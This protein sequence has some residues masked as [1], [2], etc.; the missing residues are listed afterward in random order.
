[1]KLELRHQI[2][3]WNLHLR[4]VTKYLQIVPVIGCA[5]CR[6]PGGIFSPASFSRYRCSCFLQPRVEQVLGM[7]IYLSRSCAF[8]GF[9]TFRRVTGGGYQRA[10]GNSIRHLLLRLIPMRFGMLCPLWAGIFAFS[11]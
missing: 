11:N 4:N 7:R 9:A 6:Q 8:G 2:L 1:V 5:A 3:L 10:A